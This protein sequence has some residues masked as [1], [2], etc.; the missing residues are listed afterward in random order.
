MNEH[1]RWVSKAVITCVV[2]FFFSCQTAENAVS[3]N[4]DGGADAS[5]NRGFDPSTGGGSSATNGSASVGDGMTTDTVDSNVSDT[6][7]MVDATDGSE[8]LD[9][10]DAL[11]TLDSSA[12]EDGDDQTDAQ[13]VNDGEA[14]D[15]SIDGEVGDDGDITAGMTSDDSLDGEDKSDAGD[16]DDDGVPDQEDNCVFVYNPEQ[17]DLDQD[18]EGDACDADL[19]GDGVIDELDCEPID[20]DVFPGNVEICDGFDNNCD[21]ITDAPGSAGCTEYYLDLDGDGAGVTATEECL[22]GAPSED[23]VL[24]GGDCDDELAQVSPWAKEVCDGFDDNCNLLIDDGCDDDG[25]GFCDATFTVVGTPDICPLGGGDCLDWSAAVHPNVP[26]IDGNGLDDNCDGIKAGEPI[27]GAIEPDCSGQACTGD[28]NDQLLCALDLCY[29]PGVVGPLTVSSPTGS[30]LAPNSLFGDTPYGAIE[31]F[32]SLSNDL[33]PFAGSSYLAISSGRFTH[34]NFQT[35]SASP[36]SGNTMGGAGTTDPFDVNETMNDAIEVKVTLTAPAGA[37]GFTVDYIFLSAEYEEYI[38]TAY[39]DRL[40]IILNAPQTTGG[41]NEIINFTNC[42]NPN[43]YFDFEQNGQKYC[44]IAINSAFSE[45]CSGGVVTNISG[46]GYECI[47]GSSTGWLVTSWPIT[48]GETF[49]LTFHIH[50]TSDSI[51]DSLALIDNFRWLGG[52]VEQGT[53]SKN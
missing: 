8:S 34:T 11:D 53:A 7:D 15:D 49:N 36:Q 41:V 22:C 4:V 46:T 25:D 44:Y 16:V 21:G 13:D 52:I 50:D 42:S 48:G 26:E 14:G 35:A 33:S 2:A 10:A 6:G 29:P 31:H 9:A 18:L 20:G 24:F 39:N 45:A 1:P 23:Q 40:Y 37:T 43:S 38:G 51:F 19:D 30:S 17:A 32:G 5:S 47:T 28:S 27:T 12:S 3:S